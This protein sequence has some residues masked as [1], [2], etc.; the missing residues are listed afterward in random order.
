MKYLMPKAHCAET[1]QT[2]M[3]NNLGNRFAQTQTRAAQA[4]AD[5]IAENMRFKTG[6]AWRG[7]VES[8]TVDGQG[9]TKLR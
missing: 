5:R 3:S 4:E 1:G 8:Y 9:R 7:F 2:V 6:R